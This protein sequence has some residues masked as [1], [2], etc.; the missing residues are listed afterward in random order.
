MSYFHLV[1][2]MR[3]SCAHTHVR[4]AVSDAIAIL[5]LSVAHELYLL[6]FE[7]NL[8]HVLTSVHGRRR[9]RANHSAGNISKIQNELPE[10]WRNASSGLTAVGDS[11][12]GPQIL[13]TSRTCPWKA[14]TENRRRGLF[15]QVPTLAQDRNNF[16]SEMREDVLRVVNVDLSPSHGD[17]NDTFALTHH[18]LLPHHVTVPRTRPRT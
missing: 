12:E 9:G 1:M 6:G 15:L 11:S 16:P 18:A 2:F 3:G 4:E 14:G 8:L 5:Y 10:S 7:A 13:R 17:S